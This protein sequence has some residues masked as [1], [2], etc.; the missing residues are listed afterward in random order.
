MP[1]A[2]QWLLDTEQQITPLARWQKAVDLTA[3]LFNTPVCLIVQRR[4]QGHQIAV[5]SQ[6]KA[7]PYSAGALLS[8]C[9]E[10]LSN[11]ALTRNSLLYFANK[12]QHPDWLTQ[13]MQPSPLFASF[14][15][16]PA[17]WPDGK[18]FGTLCLLDFAPT[19][20]SNTLLALINQQKE[21]I[22]TD[23]LLVQQY[24]Q[25][26]QLAACDDQT[27]LTNLPGFLAMATQ[28]VNLARH[29]RE[30]LGLVYLQL[31]GLNRLREQ[32]GTAL[33][34]TVLKGVAHTLQLHI[35]DN[36]LAARVDDNAFAILTRLKSPAAL[37]Q[38]GQRITCSLP[39][40]IAA[41]DTEQRCWLSY[42]TQLI[43]NFNQPFEFWL[44]QAH[45]TA[46][47]CSE[48]PSLIAP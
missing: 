6:H 47:Q 32:Q 20:Y 36:D 23:L 29:N 14:L 24:D 31:N 48:P 39:D 22:E 2:D 27:G 45:N 7:N 38:I 35:R 42:S 16:T 37:K 13:S 9:T 4:N 30:A 19:H 10:A 25:I 44:D 8:A 17:Y 18:S 41:S 1:H 26:R 15:A 40:I 21:S 11:Q 5:A 46:A 3:Q 28:R 33:A 34:A 12:G 43:N